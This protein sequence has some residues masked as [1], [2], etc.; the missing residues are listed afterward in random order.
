MYLIAGINLVMLSANRVEETVSWMDCVNDCL[1]EVNRET[2]CADEYE[3]LKEQ[4]V[5]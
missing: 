4:F 5:V 3:K 1:K 2:S